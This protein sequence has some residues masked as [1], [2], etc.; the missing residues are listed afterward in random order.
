M[1][2]SCLG[3]ESGMDRGDWLWQTPG[4]FGG[5]RSVL[6]LDCASGFTTVSMS[7][8]TQNYTPKIMH[9]IKCQLCVNKVEFFKKHSWVSF[10]FYSPLL[11]EHARGSCSRV[12]K[13]FWRDW[14]SESPHPITHIILGKIRRVCLEVSAVFHHQGDCCG[15]PPPKFIISALHVLFLFFQNTEK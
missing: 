7:V 14:V 3:L 15:T 4:G 9:L 11:S 8:K 10:S 5:D 12:V 1:E 2:N 6:Y 13:V